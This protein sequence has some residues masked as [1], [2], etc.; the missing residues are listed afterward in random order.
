M[1]LALI[2]AAALSL[3]AATSASA[4][5]WDAVADFTTATNGTGGSVWSYGWD[6]GAGFQLFSQHGEC[7][8][9]GLACWQSDD[10][11]F[12]VPL[13]AKNTTLTTLNYLTVVQPTDVLN[14]HPGGTNDGQVVGGSDIDTILRFTAPGAGNY[15]FN[16]FFEALDTNPTG[17]TIYAGGHLV[18]IAG[19]AAHPNTT[20]APTPFNFRAV[21]AQG[22]TV[23]FVVNRVG[24]PGG[25]TYGNDSTG[26]SLG[27]SVPEPATWGLMILGF[28]GIGA[29]LRSSRR[30]AIAATA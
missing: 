24:A 3:A 17:V 30:R 16:G 20:G 29:M 1:R 23:D 14:L 21:L 6:A 13:I 8:T 7:I 19:F 2:A 15:A 27:V 28:G 18:T 22:G 12:F 5:T 26:L 9:G 25:V 11:Q 10:P 4:A